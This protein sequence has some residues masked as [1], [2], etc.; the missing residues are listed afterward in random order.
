MSNRSK[1]EFGSVSSLGSGNTIYK[2]QYDPSVLE[3]FKNK[4]TDNDYTV[5]FDALEGTSL[6]PKTGQPDFF[7]MII[8]YIPTEDMVESKSLK[9]YLFSF[10]NTGSFHEDIVNTVGKDLVKLMNPKYLEVRGIFSVR[11]GIA[12]YPFYNYANP[13]YNYQKLAENRKLDILRDVSNRTI[14]YDM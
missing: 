10:R 13:E 5:T 3:T 8:S 14:R 12:I 2:D 7:K 11:G 1:E 6:C 9:L 4:H